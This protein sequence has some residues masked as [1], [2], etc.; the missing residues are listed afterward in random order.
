MPIL[1][2]KAS[3]AGYLS[4][5]ADSEISPAHRVWM[6]EQIKQALDRKNSGEATY[7]TLEE[8]RRRSGF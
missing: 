3:D 6:N 5:V 8:T 4:P 1:K 2:E 7:K